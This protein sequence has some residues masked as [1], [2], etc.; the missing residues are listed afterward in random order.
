VIADALMLQGKLNWRT[1]QGTGREKVPTSSACTYNLT[2]HNLQA[3]NRT[4]TLHAMVGNQWV[5]DIKQ[6]LCSAWVTLT[7]CTPPQLQLNALPLL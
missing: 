3:L 5:C 1:R 2:L 7:P 4:L 6:Q